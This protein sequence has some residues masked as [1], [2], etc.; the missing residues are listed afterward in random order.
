MTLVAPAG[1]LVAP[2]SPSAP[3]APRLLALD[4]LRGVAI[5]LVL[6]RHLPL[7]PDGTAGPF[8]A[9]MMSGWIGVDLFFV[10]S[11][12]LLATLLLREAAT[13]GTIQVARFLWRRAWRL[14]PAYWVMLLATAAWAHPSRWE[15]LRQLLFLQNYDWPRPA[16]VAL[17][18]HTW[19]LAVEEH[20]YLAL[21]WL[22]GAGRRGRPTTS[23]LLRR[24][25]LLIG[26]VVAGR[27][28][29][30]PVL[31]Q[32]YRTHVRL[33]APALGV[34]L[35]LLL[36]DPV[37]AARLARWRVRWF[38]D[39]RL[40]GLGL[41]GLSPALITLQNSPYMLGGGYTVAA[42]GSAALV[43]WAVDRPLATGA[44][45]GL[46]LRALAQGGRQCYA[47]YL[48]HQPLRT[49]VPLLVAATPLRPAWG[50]MVVLYFAS[51]ALVAI[52]LVRGIERPALAW[53]ERLV[54]AH[55]AARAA[56]APYA[57]RR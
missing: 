7:S 19:S 30:H 27:L 9:W 5:L 17:W 32:G 20:F 55:H 47:I 56:A 31:D 8:Q 25:A 26:V 43:W 16:L 39:R 10:A 57:S 51:T 15:A 6:G 36:H 45:P 14:Y 53:R 52:A 38:T 11:G 46:L 44:P 34:L 29:T 35:A 1:P 23:H 2:A 37:W 18:G 12:Y 21:P 54:P 28:L 41:L 13:T 48:V 3:V 40:L 24:V 49:I 33:D 4:V 50:A 22:L 42:L